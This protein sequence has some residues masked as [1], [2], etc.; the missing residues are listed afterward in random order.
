MSSIRPKRGRSIVAVTAGLALAASPL[1]LTSGPAVAD[2]ARQVHQAKKFAKLDLY[3]INDFHGQL[4][5]IPEDT[6]EGRTGGGE[7]NLGGTD[8]TAGG[9]AYLA[10]HLRQ[11]RKESRAQG[12]KPLTVAAGDLIG[13]T[14]LLS[15]AFHDEPT[16]EAMNLLGLKV[17]SV[18]N[19][20]FDEG[21]KE[22]QRLQDGVCL[23]DGDGANNQNSC[24][25]EENPFTGADFQ[26]LAANVKKEST[27]KT[28]LPPY[29]IKKVQGQKVG[30]IGMTLK[31]TPNIV[32]QEGV[33]GLRFTDEVKTANKLVPQLKKQGVEA[34][35]VLLHQGVAPT[36]ITDINACEGTTDTDPGLA[37]GRALDPE[38][39]L[40]ISGHTHYPYICTV[41]DPSG[42]NR[43]VTSAYS[44][45]RVV[46]KISLKIRQS[47]GD[48]MRSK[49]KAVNR[50]VTNGDGTEPVQ[51]L[52]D[53]IDRYKTLVA[54]IANKVLG[55]IAP[56]DT[57][58]TLSRTPDTDGRDSPLGNLI[59]DS[60]K[61]DS[62]T[63]PSG[64]TAPVV[65]FMNPGGIRADLLENDAK[66]I[67]YGA[68]FSVQPFNNYVV[69]MDLTGQQLLDVLNQQWNGRN[70]STDPTRYNV[71]QVSGLKY[72]WDLSDAAAVDADAI[73][74]D[75]MVDL[76][77]DGT[78]ESKLDPA[79]TYRVV[80]NSFLAGGGDGFPT[81]AEGA[82]VYFG[83][84]DIDSLA[85]YLAAHDPY[86][87]TAT[88]RISNQP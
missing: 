60:Q 64:G 59:A 38:I 10:R 82:N 18:G 42:R 35:V 32:T 9:A 83:G 84:L 66:E 3:A 40:V 4:E 73:V 55:K 24:P 67:T 17:S 31:D 88:D 68:A 12:H 22:I 11:W 26:Y 25:D 20:E 81:L 71:L 65:A 76:D 48:V 54:P 70:E 19:H 2:G 75:V 47:N 34:I 86:T 23:D 8:V 46:T 74:G 30:F 57:K 14:P 51:A 33:K 21:Y 27:G 87:P 56:A 80:V 78:A 58:D 79:K 28:I 61:A 52:L 36:P 1:A 44:T 15:A 16:I 77:R 49:T 5:T 72:T 39:D 41:K 6:R 53:L 43:L 45:G 62:S 29:T 37:I 7:V 69:S 85:D 63:I 13:A 50:V